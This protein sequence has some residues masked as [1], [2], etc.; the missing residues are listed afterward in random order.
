MTPELGL[1]EGYYGEPWTWTLREQVMR[2]LAPRGYRFFLY[3]PKADA[4]LRRR[5]REDHPSAA[6]LKLTAFAACC[7]DEGVAFGVGLSPFELYRSFDGEAKAALARKL[8]ALDRIGVE[9]V[10]LLFDDMRGDVPRLA[11]TQAEIAH[12]VAANSAA[13]RFVLCPSYYSDDAVLDRFFG[14]RPAD[15]LE[16]LGRLLDS[17]IDVFWTGEEVCAREL[18]V[19]HLQRVAGQLRRKPVLW[20]NYPVNDGPRM[21]QFLHLRAF[22]GRPAAI[23]AQIAAHAV[24]PA[25]Q[26]TL[27]LIP[28]L[29]L[30]DCYR[31]G[32]AYA[33]GA[34]FARAAAAV[35]GEELA[36][37]VREDLLLLCDTGLDRLGG[38][39]GQLRERYG[40]S[41]HPG[42]Q[43]IVAW[44]DGVY[45][46]SGE[47][48]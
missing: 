45:R 34:A 3:A 42:A 4:Y 18:S 29:T 32:E 31:Q 24:N 19:G 36:A 14:R 46:F 38:W 35:L 40:N 41:M 9:I 20:D 48:M 33:Y 37:M 25:L 21:S 5:W 28:A 11:Q 8:E 43:E 30:I 13:R 7:R 26:A 47:M 10:A 15:Y 1:V 22:T 39:N 2:F 44:L 17:R 23:G 16:D 27:S 12:W 6:E